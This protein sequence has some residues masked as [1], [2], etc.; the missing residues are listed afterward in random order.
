[1]NPGANIIR[2]QKE[3]FRVFLEEDGYFREQSLSHRRA[4]GK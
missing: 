4:W 2:E 1:M 3:T